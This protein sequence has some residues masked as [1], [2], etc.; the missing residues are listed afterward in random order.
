MIPE[1]GHLVDLFGEHTQA[2]SL[3]IEL[4]QGNISVLG[5]SVAPLGC[6]PEKQHN[7]YLISFSPSKPTSHAEL[8]GCATWGLY[9]LTL[10]C[11]VVQ[12]SVQS[13]GSWCLPPVLCPVKRCL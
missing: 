12:C 4:S 2:M 3:D 11:L 8:M 5:M 1:Q 7:N 6:S 13:G 9:L 10:P